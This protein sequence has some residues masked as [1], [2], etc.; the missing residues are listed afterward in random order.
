MALY[1]SGT[2]DYVKSISSSANS[3]AQIMGLSANALVGSIANEYNA[4]YLTAWETFVQWSAD[5][6][7]KTTSESRLLSNLETVKDWPESAATSADWSTK[8]QNPALIDVGPGNIQIK[9]ATK[10]LAK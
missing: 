5:V 3:V 1:K 4:R 10:L 9:T 6:V 8:F 2:F 7:A